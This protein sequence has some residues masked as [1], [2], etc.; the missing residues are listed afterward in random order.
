MCIRDSYVALGEYQDTNPTNG[1]GNFAKSGMAYR[2]ETYEMC[3][4]DRRTLYPTQIAYNG[5]TNWNGYSATF[6][7]PN[8]IIFQTGIRTNDWNFSFRSGFRTDLTRQL[9]NIVCQTGTQNVW[10]YSLHYG[11]SP[12]TASC[13]AS[14]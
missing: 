7:G 14:G 2:V 10:N 3:I 8:K 1:A 12:A 5:H 11:N 13:I 4:R 6:S 9:T